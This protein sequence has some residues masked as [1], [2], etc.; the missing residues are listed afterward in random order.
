[1]KKIKFGLLSLG[2]LILY[3]L[4]K[5]I[6]METIIEKIKLMG[7]AFFVLMFFPIFLQYVLFA[8][9][10]QFSL[11]GKIPSFIKIFVAHVAG[12][13]VN[14]IWSGFAGEP[15]KALFLRRHAGMH[16]ST[17]SVIISKTARSISMIVFIVLTLFYFL[18]FR[19]MPVPLKSSLFT[20]LGIITV[21]VMLFL[22]LQKKGIFA[23]LVSWMNFIKLPKWL[24]KKKVLFMQKEGHHLQKLD[25]HLIN[26]YKTE[27]GRFYFA[28]TISVLG[29]SIGA[30]E[31]YFFLKCLGTPVTLMAA[32][33]IEAFSLALNACFFFMPGG[34]GT[35]EAGKV[36]IFKLLGMLVETGLVIGLLRRIRE[37]IWTAMGLGICA[38][39]K[40][41]PSM[42][43][44]CR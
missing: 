27:S 33:T 11:N 3:Y 1:M 42:P 22:H 18:Y 4:F 38:F 2:F 44:K 15:L 10:W 32:L 36:F 29:W 16:S 40:I 5:E 7:W 43:E 23:H 24:N 35:Q 30:L 19:E 31:I 37:L 25:A 39:Y 28:V 26:F 6:G 17:A 14:Y 21:G 9:A 12:D 8:L 20:A 41:T 34:I 13:S